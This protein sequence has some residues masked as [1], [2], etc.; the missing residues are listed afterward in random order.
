M[1]FQNLRDR[2]DFSL[3]VISIIAIIT[4]GVWTY[5]QFYVSDFGNIQINVSTEYQQHSDGLRLL[6]IHV[7]PKNV[8]KAI[9]EAKRNKQKFTVKIRNIS[10]GI[11]KGV[12]DL[13]TLPESYNVDLM[14]RFPDG[15]EIDPGV[16]YDE[17]VAVVVPKDSMYAISAVL[18]INSEDEVDHTTIVRV[19]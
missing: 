2:I 18:D 3:K 19:D 15:Y 6:L 13:E 14:K 5:F 10:T 17:V 16:E 1:T 8:G 4:G 12:L 11:G 9:Y 7:K